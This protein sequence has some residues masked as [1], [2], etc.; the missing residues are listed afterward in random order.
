MPGGCG[1][2]GTVG[3]GFNGM[4]ATMAHELGH[5]LGLGH[6]PCG[7]VSGDM[8]DPN[9]PAYEPYDTV[10]AKRASIGEYGYDSSTRTV[11]SPN[12]FA[13]FMSYCGPGWISPYHYRALIEHS[14]LDP[15]WVPAARD[16]L[17]PYF[18]ERF[19][20]P[21]PHHIP[22]PPPPWVGRRL[23]LLAEPD[24]VPLVVL[25]G[26]L[27]ND[28]LEFRSVLQLRTGPV[29]SGC[30]VTGTIA[31]LLD[32]TGEVL[33]RIPL[34]RV[35]LQAGGCGCGCGGG[36]NSGTSGLV[37]ALLP[38]REGIAAIR[39]MREGKELWSRRR[40]SE[41]PRIDEVSVEVADEELRIRWHAHASDEYPTERAVRWSADD[42]RTW[43]ALAVALSEDEAVV[44]LAVLTSGH[45]L[46]QV[47]IS[48][49][50]HTTAAE[51][52]GVEIPPRAP[53]PAILWP[54]QGCAVQTGSPVR[55]WGVGTTSDGRTLPGEALRWVLDGEPV[56]TGAE[57]FAELHEREGEHR[58]TL[59]VTD[60]ELFAE[61]SVT[62]FATCSGHRPARL[63]RT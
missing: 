41:S 48:D 44:P 28:R 31:E 7:L 14:L 58:A 23:R 35:S 57:L 16:S 54:V 42:G 49:G 53:Q 8:G 13:D 21:I 50:F 46:I 40:T 25:T 38:D 55:L 19:R 6:A 17:P 60:G 33:E 9:Y 30:Q 63:G 62:F 56:G 20:D 1:G 10:N 15:Q 12:F 5:V 18:D 43:Q 47:F 59:C 27:E 45:V 51:P 32:E 36:G 22:D 52:V 34:L 37:Q 3:A 2:G 61:I 11:M 24:P 4:T 29:A 39:I 26:L